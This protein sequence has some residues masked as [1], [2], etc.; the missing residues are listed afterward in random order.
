MKYIVAVLIVLATFCGAEA[1]TVI[2][3]Q[4]TVAWDAVQPPKDVNGNPLPGEI[5]Y[6][7]YTKYGTATAAPTKVG[8]EISATQLTLTFTIEGLY[9]PCVET[10]RYPAGVT[11]PIKSSKMACSDV[12]ADTL[13]GNTFN[14]LYIVPPDSVKGL[15][16]LP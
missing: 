3:N 9:W 1:G 6:Q 16:T 8:G 7:V 13:D 12:P 14:V 4:A 15:R 10:V 2:A 11:T 5:K